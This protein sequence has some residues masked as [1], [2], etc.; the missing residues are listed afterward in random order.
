MGIK[1]VQERLRYSTSKITLN[2]YTQAISPTNLLDN[3]KS[4]ARLFWKRCNMPAS[5]NSTPDE[6]W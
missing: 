3:R 6:E 1:S 4:S 5:L 2:F